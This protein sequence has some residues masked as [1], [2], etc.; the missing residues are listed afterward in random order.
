MA[1]KKEESVSRKGLNRSISLLEENGFN[2]INNVLEKYGLYSF[3][4]RIFERMINISLC[5][6]E[7]NV[8][9]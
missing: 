3:Q 2:E 1:C 9:I 8:E 4:H 5:D 6:Q 7:I